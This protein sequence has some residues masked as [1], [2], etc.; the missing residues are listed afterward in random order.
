M[1]KKLENYTKPK[2]DLT[3]TL[4]PVLVE[5]E[6]ILAIQ[7]NVGLYDG[8]EKA[9]KYMSGNVYLTSH[10]IIYVDSERPKDNSIGVEIRL[11]KGREFYAGFVK[12]SPKITL[13]FSDSNNNL[14]PSSNN[15]PYLSSPSASTLSFQNTLSSTWICTI[16]SFSNKSQNTKC[17]LCGV[18]RPENLNSSTPPSSIS[19]SSG[20]FSQHTTTHQDSHDNNVEADESDGIACPQCTFLN[21]P[22]MINCE[23]CE[24]KLKTLDIDD[25]I[26]KED[27]V[28]LAFRNGGAI[29]FYDKMKQAMNMKGWE[30]PVESTKPPADFD[31]VR[32]G[33]SGIMRNAEKNK[34]EQDEYL[35]QAFKDMES[36]KTITEEMVKLAQSINNRLSKES[37]ESGASADEI[38]AF[39][40]DLFKLGITKD[41]AGSTY[42]QELARE[43]AEF[44][45]N[46]LVKDDKMMSLTDIYCIFNK[47]RGV[48]L[49]SPSDLQ[50]ACSL[51][52]R[53]NLP[54]RLRKFESGLSVVQS[55]AHSD[56]Q[57]A[58]RVLECIRSKGSLSA[59]EL[60]SMEQKSVVLVNEQLQM[61]E[62]K[63]LICRDESV[64][65]IRYYD[66]L[67][68]NYVWKGI[69]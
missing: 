4:R 12:S 34:K 66:N 54:F 39:K 30:K 37:A 43:L 69:N 11:I 50:K 36:L 6:T 63:G 45:E 49:I 51:F 46:V 44:L 15:N 28:K 19:S 32:G 41:E 7:D 22:Y 3:S 8:N 58:Q 55:V 56:D 64:E 52:E 18:K 26:F 68:I 27:F 35:N 31:P 16:C 42:H 61:V 14:S 24:A 23:M 2:K 29:A 25:E 33:I 62:A 57:I 40:T 1:I 21:H 38:T 13:K 53:L 59:I 65:G 60:A 17:Q 48:A 10:R 67:I 9:A 20:I 5:G 47:A